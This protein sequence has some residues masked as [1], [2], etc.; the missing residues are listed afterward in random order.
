M[1]KSI[2]IKENKIQQQLRNTIV[3][4]YHGV[5]ALGGYGTISADAFRIQMNFL[6]KNYNLISYKDLQTRSLANKKSILITLDDGY[7][8]NFLYAMPILKEYNIPAIFFIPSRHCQRNEILWFSYLKALDGFY[9]EPILTWRGVN[10]NLQG[11]QRNV[12]IQDIK[13]ILLNLSPHPSEMYKAISQEL[14][15]LDTFV[16]PEIISEYFSGISIEELK[17]IAS[18]HLFTLGIHTTDH[19]F[20]T[21]CTQEDAR[22]QIYHNMEFLKQVTI[23]APTTI[24]YPSGNYNE[25]ILEIC[26]DLNIPFGFSVIPNRK[27]W[28]NHDIPRIGIYSSSLCKLIIKISFGCQLRKLGIRIG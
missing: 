15:P 20:L 8:N 16:A 4:M 23:L 9:Q 6:E 14:P 28:N 7:H 19:A 26:K 13:K 21:N 27:S 18:D 10:Y 2:V 11:K 17:I 22:D 24:A 5:S 3:L 12:S 25:K 1:V